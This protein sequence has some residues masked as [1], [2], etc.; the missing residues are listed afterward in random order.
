MTPEELCVSRALD[1]LWE[2][3]RS[4]SLAQSEQL[5]KKNLVESKGETSWTGSFAEGE[6]HASS[7]IELKDAEGLV[8]C[9]NLNFI[10]ECEPNRLGRFLYWGMVRGE[11]CILTYTESVT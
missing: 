3:F 6:I 4:S 2:K 11:V 5:Q 1:S 8:F 10:Y 7:T 9:W